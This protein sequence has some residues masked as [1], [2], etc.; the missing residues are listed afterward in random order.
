MAANLDHLLTLTYRENMKDCR[1]AWKHFSK[2]ARLIRKRS[3]H[4]QWPYIAVQELQERGAV[5]IHVAVAGFKMST[6][7]SALALCNR[8]PW[9]RLAMSRRSSGLV[10]ILRSITR[11]MTLAGSAPLITAIR[12][13]RR[14]H[15]AHWPLTLM[16]ICRGGPPSPSAMAG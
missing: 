11:M 13:N 14:P 12:P 15:R 3:N 10:I 5:H 6:F 2:F 4:A 8:R 7:A 16:M 1:L 9:T